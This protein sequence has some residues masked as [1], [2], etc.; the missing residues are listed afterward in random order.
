MTFVAESRKLESVKT[1]TRTRPQVCCDGCYRTSPPTDYAMDEAHH[2]FRKLGWTWRLDGRTLCPICNAR[3][4]T[5][6]PPPHA[7]QDLSD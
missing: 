1:A 5:V 4:S 6:P 7:W 2:Y 3:A